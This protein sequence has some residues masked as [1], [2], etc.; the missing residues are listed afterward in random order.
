MQIVTETNHNESCYS[1]SSFFSL[2]PD[3]MDNLQANR[4]S[5]GHSNFQIPFGRVEI[6]T[7][8]N[9][10]IGSHLNLHQFNDC[11]N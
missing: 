1:V 4:Y 8:R 6:V 11:L 10:I 5:Q 3:T 2:L 9:V 7:N